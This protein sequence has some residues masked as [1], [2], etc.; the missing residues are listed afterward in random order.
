MTNAAL[1]LPGIVGWVLG[2][3]TP[4]DVPH[5]LGFCVHTFGSLKSFCKFVPLSH[6]HLSG[7]GLSFYIPLSPSLIFI[8]LVGSCYEVD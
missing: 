6:K 7:R 4:R 1:I 5:A 8:S 3:E 2:T